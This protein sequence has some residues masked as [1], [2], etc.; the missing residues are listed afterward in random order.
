MLLFLN[1]VP[2]S[3]LFLDLLIHFNKVND[4]I[5]DNTKILIGQGVYC[6]SNAI[7]ICYEVPLFEV[8]LFLYYCLKR[9]KNII[10]NLQGYH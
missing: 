3:H 5:K 2:I 10:L 4:K 9:L 6:L 8:H 7:F 1:V